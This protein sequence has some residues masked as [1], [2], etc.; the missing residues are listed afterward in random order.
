MISK[1]LFPF[2]TYCD[3]KAAVDNV[4]Q[5]SIASL[6]HSLV[7]NAGYIIKAYEER[8]TMVHWISTTEQPADIFTK[9]L[10]KDLHDKFS[11]FIFNT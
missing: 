11:S 1:N 2:N 5:G 9:P 7:K 8:I 10:K 4:Y 3:N 6:R